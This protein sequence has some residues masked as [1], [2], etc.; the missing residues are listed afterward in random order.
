MTNLDSEEIS[1][2]SCGKLLSSLISPAHVL[3]T[4]DVLES[5]NWI[6]QLNSH[7]SMLRSSVQ[8]EQIPPASGMLNGIFDE[9]L[10]RPRLVRAFDLLR[11][12]PK[13]ECSLLLLDPDVSDAAVQLHCERENVV[14]V[15]TVAHDEASVWFVR[16]NFL[17]RLRRQSSP[18]PAALEA[19]ITSER[20]QSQPKFAL[21][22]RTFSMFAAKSIVV[23]LFFSINGLFGDSAAFLSSAKNFFECFVDRH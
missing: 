19:E 20:A 23:S 6:E 8:E 11:A 22:S 3:E 7:G 13:R 2:K 4:L 12:R 18:V 17:G 14:Q 9:L 15:W 5:G 10:D 21:T 16:E 1:W